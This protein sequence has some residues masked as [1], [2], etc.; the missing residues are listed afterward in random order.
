METGRIKSVELNDAR[1]GIMSQSQFAM[2]IADGIND[3]QFAPDGSMYV[4][5]STAIWRITQAK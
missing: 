2:G 4:L 1:D 3:V 5:T